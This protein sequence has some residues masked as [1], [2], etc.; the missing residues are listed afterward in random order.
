MEQ[1]PVGWQEEGKMPIPSRN[2]FGYYGNTS[3]RKTKSSR[4]M[5]NIKFRGGLKE[6]SSRW[7]RK[8]GVELRV[9]GG[10]RAKLGIQMEGGER[11]CLE[12]LTD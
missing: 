10:V 7:D 12:S 2:D 1:S 8:V 3:H 5:V 6:G 11:T 9:E 4:R